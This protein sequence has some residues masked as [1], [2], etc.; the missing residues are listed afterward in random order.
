M[1]RKYLNMHIDKATPKKWTRKEKLV[2][3]IEC[4]GIISLFIFFGFLLLI[5][6]ILE[7]YLLGL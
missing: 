7:N 3:T 5:S 2:L 4:L 6:D 1:N